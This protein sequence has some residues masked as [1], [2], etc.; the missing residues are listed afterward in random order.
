M[1]FCFPQTGQREARGDP[2]GTQFCPAVCSIVLRNHFWFWKPYTDNRREPTKKLIQKYLTSVGRGCP[3]ILN[4]APDRMGLV[5]SYDM[6]SYKKFG[7]TIQ[8]LYSEPILQVG[9]PKFSVGKYRTWHLL[10]S[11]K[12]TNG[13]VVLMED[14][15]KFGQLVKSYQITY[16]MESSELNHRENGTTVGH[17]RIHPFPWQPLGVVEEDQEPPSIVGIRIKIT[18]LVTNAPVIRLRKVSM[19]DWSNAVAKG[20]L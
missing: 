10:H 16:L 6:W 15:E 2:N 9:R 20:I 8:M 18:Q 3:L 12:A 11:L 14:V 13:S 5:P 4:I 1:T 19:F 7:E 17:K